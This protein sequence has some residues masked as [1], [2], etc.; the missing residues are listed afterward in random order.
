MSNKSLNKYISFYL[1]TFLYF[2]I[3]DLNFYTN[4]NNKNQGVQITAQ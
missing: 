3:A 4:N 1:E 2:E